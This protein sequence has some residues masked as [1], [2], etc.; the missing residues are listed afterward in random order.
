[1]IDSINNWKLSQELLD[2]DLFVCSTKFAE[3][4]K[5]LIEAISVGIPCIINKN[6]HVPE[7][8]NTNYLI[9]VDDNP[10]EYLKAIKM[11]MSDRKIR[12]QIGKKG[13]FFALN[14]LNIKNNED[15]FLDYL[16]NK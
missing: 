14:E 11:L 2:A 6:A 3:F 1:M 13:K 8:N 4:P 10:K 7:L 15:I 16:I 9:Q 12:E 5:T